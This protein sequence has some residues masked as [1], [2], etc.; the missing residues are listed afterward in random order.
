MD[1]LSPIYGASGDSRHYL[2]QNNS[3]LAC[4]YD[5]VQFFGLRFGVSLG[6]LN[7]IHDFESVIKTTV[8]FYDPELWN[9]I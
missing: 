9:R 3:S 1:Y 6:L 5:P 7:L 4:H 8:V 2:G